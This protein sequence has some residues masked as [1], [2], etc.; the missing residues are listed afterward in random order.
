MRGQPVG[1]G[2]LAV[3]ARGWA[4]RGSGRTHAPRS[5]RARRRR[6]RGVSRWVS[7]SGCTAAVSVV[8]TASRPY[9]RLTVRR[10]RSANM[11]HMTDTLLRRDLGRRV[12]G[13]GAMGAGI[14]QVA[15]TG[16]RAVH[17]VDA[18]PGAAAAAPSSGS[19]RPW[20]GSPTRAGS[21]GDDADAADRP[22]DRRRRGRRPARRAPWSSRPIRED[23]DAKRA[24]FAELA[25]R[26]PA[27][28]LLATQHLQPR[29]RAPSPTASPTR[30]ACSACTSSTRRR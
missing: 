29:H 30:S 6:A 8:V 21:A 5:A 22:A 9:L 27:D 24:L 17:L 7:V 1:G 28:T 3:D 23:L 16:R 4:T 11:C 13:T 15:A 12:V 18:V 20:T 2:G 10:Q 14:A 19:P 25:E 26:Q